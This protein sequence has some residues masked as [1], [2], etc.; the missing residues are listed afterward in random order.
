VEFQYTKVT[1]V[2]IML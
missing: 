1:V 2:L